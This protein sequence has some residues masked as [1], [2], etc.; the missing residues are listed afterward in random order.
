MSLLK[1]FIKIKLNSH[2]IDKKREAIS[3]I[4]SLTSMGVDCL[5]TAGTSIF[6]LVRSASTF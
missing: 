3:D 2:K 1:V 6:K 4:A 5:P